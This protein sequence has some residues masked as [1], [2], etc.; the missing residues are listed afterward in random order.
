MCVYVCVLFIYTI[1]ISVICV[2]QEETDLIASNQQIYDFYKLIIEIFEKYRHWKVNFWY[3]WII[4]LINYC[5]KGS[6]CEYIKGGVNIY[7]YGC[8]SLLALEC[9]VYVCAVVCVCDIKSEYQ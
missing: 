8:V 5:N 3:H 1:S 7:L 2:S 6:C 4:Y 9:A